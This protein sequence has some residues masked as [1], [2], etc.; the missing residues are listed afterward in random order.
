M[1]EEGEGTG[2]G[3]EEEIR[4]AAAEA[5][6]EALEQAPTLEETHHS[7]SVHTSRL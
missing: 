3:L 5:E 1:E 6:E 2:G 7:A 4:V